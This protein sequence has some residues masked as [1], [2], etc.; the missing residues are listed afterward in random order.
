[1]LSSFASS[2][3]RRSFLPSFPFYFGISLSR[4]NAFRVNQLIFQQTM[5]YEAID[6]SKIDQTLLESPIGRLRSYRTMPIMFFK[7]SFAEGESSS[8]K[9]YH[10][11]LQLMET[12]ETF[13]SLLIVL[14]HD[15]L[16]L[17]EIIVKQ[18]VKLNKILITGIV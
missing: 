14:I 16:K 6:R 3:D 9:N 2:R 7:L 12:L 15:G 10:R 4:L 18:V 13:F 17:E 5:I 1:M 8:C 11:N